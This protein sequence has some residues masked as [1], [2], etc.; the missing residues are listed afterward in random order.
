MPIHPTTLPHPP[1][2][3]GAG[4]D[5]MLITMPATLNEPLSTLQRVSEVMEY[6]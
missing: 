4:A 2:Q 3:P 6:R 1:C 5:P